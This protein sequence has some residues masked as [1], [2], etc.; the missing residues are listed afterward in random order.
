MTDSPQVQ[1]LSVFCGSKLGNNSAYAEAA[2]ALGIA[3]GLRKIDLIYGG[4]TVGLMGTIADAVLQT[5]GKVT[6]VIPEKLF[7]HETQHPG[8]TE[9]LTVKNMH[10]RKATMGN[11]S[12]G[13]IALPGGFGTLEELLETITWSQLKIH[14]KPIGILNVGGYYGCLVSLI[15]QAIDS[16]FIKPQHRHLYFVDECAENLLDQIE[17]QHLARLGNTQQ[18]R[19]RNLRTG[20][21]GQPVKD[22]Q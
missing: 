10:E 16:G 6:G 18:Q 22:G 1:R 4:S 13:F 7:D 17:K 5:G 15:E 8:I 9:L 14:N 12:D 3:M 11:L 21:Q 20:M 19:T 2:T